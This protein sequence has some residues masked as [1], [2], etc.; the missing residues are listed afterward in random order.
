[1][2]SRKFLIAQIF[3]LICAAALVFYH[4]RKPARVAIPIYGQVADFA[5]VDQ[6]GKIVHLSDFKGKVWVADFIFTTCS[7]IC[8]TMSRNMSVLHH[9]FASR[10]DLRLVSISVNP[11]NDTPERLQDYAKRYKAQGDQWIFLTGKRDVIQ[12]LAVKS[13]QMGDMKEILFHSAYFALVDRQGNIRGYYDATDEQRL[14][15]L[16]IDI[17]GILEEQ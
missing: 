5:L 1:M 14:V 16:N 8:P 3:F 15:Q 6:F 10:P 9:N 7:G 17:K 13:F 11:E 12:H 4:V 2:F